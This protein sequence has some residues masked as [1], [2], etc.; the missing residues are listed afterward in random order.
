MMQPAILLIAYHFPPSN[1]VGGARLFRFYKY[2]KRLGYDCRVV[3]L[4][5]GRQVASAR[6]ADHHFTFHRSLWLRFFGR[7]SR[8]HAAGKKAFSKVG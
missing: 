1:A 7:Y 2:L 4:D 6:V 5:D 3:D 8:A